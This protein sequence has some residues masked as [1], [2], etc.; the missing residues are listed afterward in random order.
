MKQYEQKV[1]NVDYTKDLINIAL[2]KEEW[3]WVECWTY[4]NTK[5]EYERIGVDWFLDLYWIIIYPIRT[6]LMFSGKD[7]SENKNIEFGIP[8]PLLRAFVFSVG[9]FCYDVDM[10][11]VL[12][13]VAQEIIEKINKQLKEQLLKGDKWFQDNF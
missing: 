12:N 3:R 13:M 9:R 11:G 1:Y 2:T 8:R 4:T 10:R 7:F 5:K 6:E